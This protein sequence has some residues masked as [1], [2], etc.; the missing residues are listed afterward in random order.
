MARVSFSKEAEN[1]L[2]SIFHY[3]IETYGKTKADEYYAIILRSLETAARFPELGRPHR[4]QAGKAFRQFNVGR[5][6]VFYQEEENGI[7]IVRVL[8]QAMNFDRHLG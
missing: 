1:D 2:F 6:S 5:H 7:F 4:T 3:T 8:H